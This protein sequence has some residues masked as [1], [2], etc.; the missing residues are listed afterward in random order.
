[1]EFSM[2]RDYKAA[3]KAAVNG[4][5]QGGESEMESALWDVLEAIDSEMAELLHDTPEAAFA[6]VNDEEM[7]E[8]EEEEFNEFDMIGSE[9][10]Y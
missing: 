8:E 7:E 6:K 1:M 2:R 4:L 9:E 5:Y 10:E 3:V